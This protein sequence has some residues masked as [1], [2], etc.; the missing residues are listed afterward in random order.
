[1]VVNIAL[2]SGSAIEPFGDDRISD[3]LSEK[4]CILKV[5]EGVRVN[6]NLLGLISFSIALE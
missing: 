5:S 6:G 3:A 1:M 4:L 2:R